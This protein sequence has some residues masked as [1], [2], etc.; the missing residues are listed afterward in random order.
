GCPS[1]VERVPHP[2]RTAP[3]CGRVGYRAQRDRL[4]PTTQQPPR[5]TL[6]PT[7]KALSSFREAGGPAVAV[8]SA[9]AVDSAVAVASLVVIPKGSASRPFRRCCRCIPP[10]KERHLDRSSGQ[11]PRRCAAHV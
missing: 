3:S 11:H 8:A 9:V 10:R 1:R 5:N 2:R 4:L 7:P 6:N